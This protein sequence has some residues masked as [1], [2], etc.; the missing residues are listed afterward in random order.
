MATLWEVITENSTLPVNDS[1]SFWDHMQ[2]QGVAG[3]G[4]DRT[5][6]TPFKSSIKHSTSSRVKEVLV[7]TLENNRTSATI[8][9]YTT[10]QVIK[11]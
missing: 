3:T 5:F 8:K 4:V 11:T 10:A 2:N 1:N 6:Y 9:N 7:A